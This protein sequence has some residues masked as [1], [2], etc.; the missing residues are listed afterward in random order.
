MLRHLRAIFD[1]ANAI[2]MIP[3]LCEMFIRIVRVAMWLKRTA[4]HA[5]QK[6]KQKQDRA[7]SYFVPSVQNAEEMQRMVQCQY[8]SAWRMPRGTTSE[9]RM[10][11]LKIH[12]LAGAVE[13]GRNSLPLCTS[14]NRNWRKRFIRKIRDVD[15]DVDYQK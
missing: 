14:E 1:R 5:A 10:E 12:S 3:R 4:H 2:L 7:T 11:A 9:T 13:L 6:R 15:F 8:I